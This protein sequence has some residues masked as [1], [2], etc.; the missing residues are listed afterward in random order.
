MSKKIFAC[1]ATILALTSNSCS[2]FQI[3]PNHKMISHCFNKLF[4]A[5]NI[6]AKKNDSKT[7]KELCDDRWCNDYS[8]LSSDIDWLEDYITQKKV[9]HYNCAQ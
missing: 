1:L 5:K 3:K 7:L 2:V 4:E 8:K 6:A 9:S